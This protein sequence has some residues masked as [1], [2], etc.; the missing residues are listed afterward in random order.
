MIGDAALLVG[1]LRFSVDDVN[2]SDSITVESGVTHMLATLCALQHRVR[3]AS[4]KLVEMGHGE[5]NSVYLKAGLSLGSVVAAV[6]GRSGLMFDVFGDSVNR[7]SRSKSHCPPGSIAFEYHS[8]IEAGLVPFQTKLALAN[9][10][11]TQ[12]KGI[13]TPIDLCVHKFN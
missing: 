2:R 10:F 12:F 13:S 7:A 11:Q 3:T 5:A 9:R 6:V 1:P 4:A 8:A